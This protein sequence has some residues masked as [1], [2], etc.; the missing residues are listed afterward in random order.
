[1]AL[2]FSNRMLECRAV[3]HSDDKIL[4]FG[5]ETAFSEVT[6]GF[7]FEDGGTAFVDAL[8]KRQSSFGSLH[9]AARIENGN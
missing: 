4:S 6:G 8:G 2:G 3:R 1:M 7:V 5:F 9:I